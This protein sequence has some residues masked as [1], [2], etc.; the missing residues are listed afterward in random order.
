M[1]VSIINDFASLGAALKQREQAKQPAKVADVPTEPVNNYPAPNWADIYTNAPAVDY[2]G[3]VDLDTGHGPMAADI[4]A[5]GGTVYAQHADGRA[6]AWGW[7]EPPKTLADYE[8]KYGPGSRCPPMP[9]L[10]YVV[11][12]VFNPDDYK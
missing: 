6:A 4:I 2:T 8:A 7:P 9:K 5:D 10:R 12:S 1:T 11:G 3:W